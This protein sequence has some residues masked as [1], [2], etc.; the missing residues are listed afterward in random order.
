M[1]L[2]LRD[3]KR[4]GLREQARSF[5]KHQAVLGRRLTVGKLAEAI[6]LDFDK[7]RRAWAYAWSL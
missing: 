3:R 5:L 6:R 4:A 2:A 1:L 7:H